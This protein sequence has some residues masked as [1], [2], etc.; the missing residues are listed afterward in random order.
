MEALL[1]F[2]E[3]DSASRWVHRESKLVFTLNSD[4]DQRKKFAF[5]LAFAQ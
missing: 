1:G 5:V 4:K 2:S 3:S